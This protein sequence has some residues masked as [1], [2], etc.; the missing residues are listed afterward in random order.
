M[1]NETRQK[2]VTDALDMMETLRQAINEAGGMI[3]DKELRNMRVDT[4]I[5]HLCTNG[6]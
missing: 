1:R 3:S 6:I 4:M 2:I 5:S